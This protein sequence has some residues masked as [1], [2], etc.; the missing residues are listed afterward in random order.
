MRISDWSSDVCSSDLIIPISVVH[1]HMGSE[2]WTFEAGPGTI[3]DSV[4]GAAKLHEVY[5]TAKPDYSGRVTV[6]VLWDKLRR[7]IVSNES[8]EIVRMFNS[9]FDPRSE[10]HTSELQSLMRISYAV[11]CLK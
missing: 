6:P 1:W 2:G 4:N 3:P 5:T 9:A 11:F 8:A 7:T 10:E